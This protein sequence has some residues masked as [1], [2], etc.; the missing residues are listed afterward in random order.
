MKLLH[1]QYDYIILS[2]KENNLYMIILI[3]HNNMDIY[4]RNLN[5]QLLDWSLICLR[6][7]VSEFQSMIKQ[8]SRLINN[9]V[10]KAYKIYLLLRRTVFDCVDY[11]FVHM[12]SSSTSDLVKD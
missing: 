9:I 10:D 6:V 5:Q 7:I 4:H 11:I 8:M 3:N 12:F 2:Y 1:A